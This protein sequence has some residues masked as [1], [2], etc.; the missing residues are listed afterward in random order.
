MFID[1]FEV[2]RDERLGV[3]ASADTLALIAC[4]GR[5]GGGT[6][7]QALQADKVL[8]RLREA[9]HWLACSCRGE[10]PLARLVPAHGPDGVGHT[11][12]R[13]GPVP[14]APGCPF[15]AAEEGAGEE[16]ALAGPGR[17]LAAPA[18]PAW[19]ELL[20]ELADWRR[21]PAP[22]RALRVALH[23][24][25]AR[26]GLARV[27]VPQLT[28]RGRGIAASDIPAHY[29]QLGGLLREPAGDRTLGAVAT[30]HPAGVAGLLAHAPAGSWGL[31]L[32]VV[33][34]VRPLVGGVS[35][36]EAVV[37]GRTLEFPLAEPVDGVIGQGPY[38]V[39]AAGQR[40]EAGF[41]ELRAAV[42]MPLF[43]RSLLM[44]IASAAERH[45]LAIVLDQIRYWA[46]RPEAVSVSVSK[47][48]S[49]EGLLA[50]WALDQGDQVLRIGPDGDAPSLGA[51]GDEAE[52]AWR[53]L[54]TARV[55]GA[56]SRS[57]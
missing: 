6:A 53:R 43:S 2:T 10:E 34:N 39:L 32:L 49:H 23:H 56:R 37:G 1:L 52:M 40:A 41:F 3:L 47:P 30:V 48:L 31:A 5:A 44:P 18:P 27:T 21:G 8:A 7:W 4:H 28:A 35:V 50:G 17:P 20:G 11:I 46:T 38:A 33:A 45:E 13:L 29:G 36:L 54:L 19:A 51:G 24:A 9:G 22:V 14:H 26:A 55:L 12:R 15:G 25:W 57:A 16:P 42:A